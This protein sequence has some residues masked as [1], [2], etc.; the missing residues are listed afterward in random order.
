MLNLLRNWS[1]S[2]LERMA[3]KKSAKNVSTVE[4]LEFRFVIISPDIAGYN[5]TQQ[6]W[7]GKIRKIYIKS[8]YCTWN[9]PKCYKLVRVA[10]H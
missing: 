1:N 7:A 3:K 9:G 5:G 6:R 10:Y 8:R 4:L 2:D